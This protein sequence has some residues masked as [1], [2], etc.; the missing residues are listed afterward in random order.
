MDFIYE[1]LLTAL[2]SVLLAFLVGKIFAIDGDEPEDE[3]VAERDGKQEKQ[4]R[5]DGGVDFEGSAECQEKR[6]GLGV[7]F[8]GEAR[9]MAE[10]CNPDRIGGGGDGSGVE[11][12]GGEERRSRD[13]GF[14]KGMSEGVDREV[15]IGGVNV[16]R[17][18][19]GGLEEVGGGEE[20]GFE[21]DGVVRVEESRAMV[22]DV[23]S[24]V[25]AR[26][27]E[28]QTEVERFGVVEE[29]EWKNMESEKRSQDR[30]EEPE[31]EKE[32]VE[33][34]RYFAALGKEDES[35]RTGEVGVD[36][37]A[38]QSEKQMEIKEESE[39]RSDKHAEMAMPEEMELEKVYEEERSALD[40]VGPERLDQPFQGDKEQE[41]GHE[42][43]IGEEVRVEINQVGSLL[44]DED[45]WEGIER[46]ELLERFGEANAYIGSGSGTDAISKLSSDMQMQLYGLHKVATEGPCFEPQP[47]ALKISA[48]SKWHAWQRLGSMNPE[49]AMEKYMELLSEQI[50]EWSREKTTVDSKQ[51]GSKDFEVAEMP[52]VEP[53]DQSSPLP[54]QLSETRSKQ[55]EKTWT[56]GDAVVDPKVIEPGPLSPQPE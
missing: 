38:R 35:L 31:V 19:G 24:V 33:S 8:G 17:E 9:V 51:D 11:K 47:L 22:C 34:E 28:V 53:P 46:S 4:E 37:V 42:C 18:E 44:D 55:E 30:I 5:G 27:G 23:C 6:E 40:E 21:G 45:E 29:F 26:A 13:G 16:V 36:E 41:K 12:G 39:F 48:R 54:Y 3:R 2:L 14:V 20:I 43:Q 49:V 15:V 56:E 50:P 32:V 1:L 10:A 25:E 52:V 7:S